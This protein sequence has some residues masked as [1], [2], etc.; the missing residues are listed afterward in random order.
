[1]D[2]DLKGRTVL[3][4]GASK[5]IGYACAESFLREGAKVIIT[6]R[7]EARLQEAAAKLN[8]GAAVKTFAGDLGADEDRKKL[9]SAHPDV[10]VLVNNAGAIPGGSLFDVDLAKWKASWELK[11]FGYVHLTALYLDAMRARK[12]GLIVNVIGMAGQEPRWEYICGS[13]GNAALMAMTQAAGAKSPDWNVRVVGVN[14]SP[15]RTDRI[16]SLFRRK[17]QETFG[18]ESRWREFQEKLPFGRLAEASEVADVVVMLA[19]PRA[20]Y[21]SGSIVEIDGGQRNRG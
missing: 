15:T 2:L 9:F 6:G 8:A 1:M 3:I 19:S 13:A 16:E 20:A 4:T 7:A 11:V 10:D 14:P 21:V 17:A 18:D 12:S 5:G